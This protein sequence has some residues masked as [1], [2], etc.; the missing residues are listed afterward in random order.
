MIE[1]ADPTGDGRV[2]FSGTNGHFHIRVIM[3]IYV[4]C[5]LTD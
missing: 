2:N 4:F 5:F 3:T 1:E